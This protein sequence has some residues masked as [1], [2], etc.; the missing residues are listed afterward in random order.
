ML[1]STFKSIVQPTP[2]LEEVSLI[3][4]LIQIAYGAYHRDKD[5]QTKESTADLVTETDK[6]VEELIISELKQRFP[7]HRCVVNCDRICPLLCR[8]GIVRKSI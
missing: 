2:L 7:T 3:H 8:Y 1:G 5:V 4:S 6:K